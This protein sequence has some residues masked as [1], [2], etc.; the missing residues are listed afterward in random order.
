M[1]SWMRSV[2]CHCWCCVG[3]GVALHMAGQI[4]ACQTAAAAAMAWMLGHSRLD[5]Q[6]DEVGTVPLLVL[7]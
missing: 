5:E 1:N 2:L 7:R 4:S 3:L 6:L